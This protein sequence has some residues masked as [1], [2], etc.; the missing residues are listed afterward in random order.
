MKKIA[1]LFA[2]SVGALFASCTG[3][4]TLPTSTGAAGEILMVIN[5]DVFKSNVGDSIVQ[6]LNHDVPCMPQAEPMFNISRTNFEGFTSIIKPARNII[7]IDA[8][9]AYSSVKIKTE[10]DKW[11]KP[12]AIL[13]I[14]GPTTQE[15][16][17]AIGKYKVQIANYFVKAE[18]DRAIK[19]HQRYTEKEMVKKV[20]EHMGFYMAVPRNMVR[21]KKAENFMWI[22][23]NA[24]NMN[25]N[26]VLYSYPYTEA[27]AF[28]RAKLLQKRDSVMKLHIPGPVENSYMTTEY[29]FE[30]PI[31]EETAMANKQYAI[32]IQGMWRVEGEY[33]GGPFVSISCLDQKNQRIIT[34]EAFIYAPNQYKRNA[35]RQ[36]EAAL[37]TIKP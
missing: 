25:R 30:P 31:W 10:E 5:E 26:I 24:G 12:Q 22:S 20:E 35:M 37:Y 17:D 27:D 2:L 33:M 7:L 16:A 13:T 1:Y 29:R 9:R 23:N 8:G 19:H 4:P 28:T 32:R 3:A 36:L 34:A 14:Q 21:C 15:V 6:I 11:G 18:R